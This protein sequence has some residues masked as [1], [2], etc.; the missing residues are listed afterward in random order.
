LERV[1]NALSEQGQH[2]NA[3]RLNGFLPFIFIL[4]VMFVSVLPGRAMQETD[5]GVLRVN[6]RLVLLDVI[7]RD[8]DGLVEDLKAEDFTLLDGGVERPIAVFTMTRS[9]PDPD[10]VPLPD[11]VVSNRLDA[12]GQTPTSATAILIDRLN[13]PPGMQVFA[14]Q[15]VNEFLESVVDGDRVAVYELT[16]TLRMLH[17]YTM[18]PRAALEAFDGGGP[19]QI[20]GL[21][22][23]ID[24]LNVE[25]GDRELA[26]FLGG[27]GAEEDVPGPMATF[28]NLVERSYL[29]MRADTTAAALEAIVLNLASLPGRKNL[30]WVSG[31]FPFS[32]EPY[33]HNAFSFSVRNPTL[34]RLETTGRIL[35]DANVAV[36]PIFAGG[37]G[38][39]DPVIQA[40]T[41][42]NPLVQSGLELMMDLADRTGG[43][44]SF[45]TNGLATRM[46]EA[47]EDTR[48]S[49]TL[50][51]Y[52]NDDELDEEFHELE[53]RT[54]PPDL[55]VRHREGYWGF[56]AAR[57]TQVTPGLVNLLIAPTNATAVGLTASV[58]PVDGQPGHLDL[59]VIADTRDL[60]LT[61]DGTLWHGHLEMAMYFAIPEGET[62]LLP[63]QDLVI[64]M[65]DADFQAVQETGYLILTR[66]ETDGLSG[67]MRLV[68]RDQA[69]GQAGSLRVP[70]GLR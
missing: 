65:S 27:G 1:L 47:V 70:I 53:V 54:R 9:E 8:D 18:D 64:Q 22:G 41:R 43:E 67:W 23:S 10:A 25:I 6:T 12:R 55:E 3:K 62:L 20:I 48:V 5:D 68:V 46:E 63:V 34:D 57:P 29:G 24:A 66:L 38:G 49:Y 39:A 51:F 58:V 16:N 19:I 21:E 32:F 15:Q 56:G 2:A 61:F 45:N 42:T 69:S 40:G 30:V 44:V 60:G 7:V 13:T 31:S 59:V 4:G 50:G 11:G 33:Q 37:L 17:D 28:V 35:T 52:V 26:E 14:D 36:Y